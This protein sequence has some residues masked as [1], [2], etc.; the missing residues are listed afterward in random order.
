MAYGRRQFEIAHVSAAEADAVIGWRRLS[1]SVTLQPEC[2]PMPTQET[3]RRSVRC[4][5]IS[6]S[7]SWGRARAY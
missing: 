2:R 3:E 6:L 7:R 4:A 5:S 1:E